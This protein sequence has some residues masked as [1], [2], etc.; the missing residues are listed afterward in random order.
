MQKV[1]DIKLIKQEEIKG[2]LEPAHSCTIILNSL[3][4][5]LY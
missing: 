4:I 5:K 3:M 1:L 2:L